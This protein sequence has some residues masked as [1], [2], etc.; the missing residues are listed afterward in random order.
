VV[1]A[2]AAGALLMCAQETRALLGRPGK[3]NSVFAASLRGTAT[4][5]TSPGWQWEHKLQLEARGVVRHLDTSAM[6]AGHRSDQTEAQPVPAR[7]AA[8]FQPVKALEDLLTFVDGGFLARHRRSKQRRRNCPARPAPCATGTAVLDRV[9]DE[10][11]HGIEQKVSVASH[12]QG[13]IRDRTQAR[14]FF[15]RGGIKQ[16]HHLAGDAGKVDCA[17]PSH[18][19]ARLDLRD[20]R[21]RGEQGQDGIEVRQ[22]LA[23]QRLVVLAVARARIGFFPAARAYGPR[24]SCATLSVTCFTSPINPSMRSSIRLRLSAS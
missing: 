12:K 24:A 14:T 8:A 13:S 17:E 15:L 2:G 11:R 18:S 20:P 16:L 10:I 1:A 6:Q 9:V 4:V 7:A 5:A 3:S 19:I 21:E 23:D 22:G